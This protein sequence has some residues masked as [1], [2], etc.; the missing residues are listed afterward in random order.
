[1][2]PRGGFFGVSFNSFQT[3]KWVPICMALAVPQ[4]RVC[5][6][7]SLQDG[8]GRTASHSHIHLLPV[9]LVLVVHGALED[10]GGQVARRAADLCEEGAQHPP[11]PPGRVCAVPPPPLQAVGE[12]VWIPGGIFAVMLLTRE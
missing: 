5:F 9:A 2:A 1:M 10:L 6:G 7:S 11:E 3:L 12:G 4:S 8:V